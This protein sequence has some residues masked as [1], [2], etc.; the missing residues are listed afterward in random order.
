MGRQ[1]PEQW[2]P[3]SGSR[4]ELVTLLPAG[5]PFSGIWPIPRREISRLRQIH[6]RNRLPGLINS[7]GFRHPLL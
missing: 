1:L 2:S 5:Q 3:F 4:Y 6:R 7:H